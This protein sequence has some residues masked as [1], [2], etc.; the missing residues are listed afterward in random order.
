MN[1]D[2]TPRLKWALEQVKALEYAATTRWTFYRIADKF[3]LPKSAYKLFLKASGARRKEFK[4][5][6]TPYTLK[7][8]SRSAKK[9]GDGATNYSMFKLWFGQAPDVDVWEFSPIYVEAWVEASAMM[10][11]FEYL[12]TGITLRPL[13]GDWSIDGKWK[14]TDEIAK[15]ISDGKAVYI[16][17]FGDCDKKGR[18]IPVS[19][20]NQIRRW[21]MDETARTHLIAKV[22]AEPKLKFIYAGLTEAQARE[23]KLI[24]SV[25]EKAKPGEYQWESLSDEQAREIIKFALENIP[26]DELEEAREEARATRRDWTKRYF[27]ELKLKGGHPGGQ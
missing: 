23:F 10:A 3:N 7:D 4:D 18:E 9:G 5:G 25:G 16:L 24:E 6:W 2:W 26:L 12:L 22:E 11:Q 1:I 19:A 17:Y 20:W 14:A 15:R 21:L 27:K 13:K 8:D